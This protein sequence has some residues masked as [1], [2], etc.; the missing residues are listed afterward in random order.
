MKYRVE[1]LKVESSSNASITTREKSVNVASKKLLPN[2]ITMDGD[3]RHLSHEDSQ[4]FEISPPGL[5][6]H[7]KRQ[8]VCATL[9]VSS[10]QKILKKKGCCA[11]QNKRYYFYS[12]VGA[13]AT[14]DS[15]KW[16]TVAEWKKCV[17]VFSTFGL[18]GGDLGQMLF[19]KSKALRRKRLKGEDSQRGKVD[20]Y[21]KSVMEELL[22]D[23]G[24]KPEGFSVENE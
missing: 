23:S 15:A 14:A 21:H 12:E 19:T 7:L 8:Q 24:I 3:K 1:N 18:T 4:G 16:K 10:K 20:V 9:L 6:N 22:A 17:S 2:R 13:S 5:R 11:S